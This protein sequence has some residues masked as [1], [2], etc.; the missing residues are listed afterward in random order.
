[1]KK[2]RIVVCLIVLV[3]VLGLT[4]TACTFANSDGK[5]LLGRITDS[6]TDS[7]NDKNN[8]GGTGGNNLSGGLAGATNL[9]DIDLT[10]TLSPANDTRELPDIIE[11]IQDSVVVINV[12]VS[13]GTSA[14]SGVILASPASEGY[15]YIITCLHVVEG[16][17]AIKVT[18]TNGE[19]YTADFVGG[20]PD[21]DIAMLRIPV[22]EGITSAAIRNVSQK[23]VRTGE[24]AIAIGNPLG[25]L[26]GTVTN[27]IISA[28]KREINI[29][30][31]MMTLLQTNAEINSGNSGGGLF[32]GN[33]LLIGIVNAKSTGSSVEGLGFAIP[34]EIATDI[35]QK[36]LDTRGNTN[37][38]GLGY[39]S[40]K[41][42]LGI[43]TQSGTYNLS[44]T[45]YYA[46]QI[47]EMNL[48]GSAASSGLQSG[49]YIIQADN[50][51]L[52]E[53]RTLGT[54]L[55]SKNIGDT[56]ILNVM[57]REAYSQGLF[58]QYR[59]NAHSITI[60]LKQYVYGY[61]Q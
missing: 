50:A 3:S 16:Y 39:I 60:T 45:D 22:I 38:N 23:P 4:L 54:V 1:M 28:T 46:S 25:T 27:G 33:G 8:S 41:K 30:G 57:R 20:V 13:G 56:I 53:S 52:S 7:I 19:T 11:D 47:T 49:D 37:Y 10:T 18:L 40:G 9:A 42:M 59:Y 48:Y 15:S 58:T 12:T 17:S 44:G 29:E 36:L 35:A 6:I 61:E 51:N 32:D 21:N 26:G 31:S 2:F 24:D 34:I 5:G 43:T 14:G 55:S